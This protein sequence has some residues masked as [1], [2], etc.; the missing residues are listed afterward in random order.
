LKRFLIYLILIAVIAL[1][2]VGIY[3]EFVAP[4]LLGNTSIP[5]KLNPKKINSISITGNDGAFLLN[6]DGTWIVTQSLNGKELSVRADQ[7][8]V[9]ELLHVIFNMK[10][11]TAV[12]GYSSE[13]AEE[14]GFDNPVVDL[15]LQEEDRSTQLLF[16]P[17]KGHKGLYTWLSSRAQRLYRVDDFLL[18]R[19][20]RPFLYYQNR[21]VLPF[22]PTKVTRFQLTQRYAGGWTVVRDKEGF[23]FELPLYL[24]DK[25]ASSSEIRFYLLMLAGLN[26]DGFLPSGTKLPSEPEAILTVWGASDSPLLMKI[27]K[28]AFNVGGDFL[29]TSSFQ[30]GIFRLDNES[31]RQLLKTPFDLQSRNVVDLDIGKVA[32]ITVRDFDRTSS[33]HKVADGWISEN[34]KKRVTGIDMSLW[35]F[36]ELKFEALPLKTLPKTAS[37]LMSCEL[38]D[39]NDNNIIALKFFSDSTLPSGQSWLKSDGELYYPVANQIMNDLRG[40]LPRKSMK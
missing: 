35:R 21:L 9:D 10:P 6:R 5:L 7:G 29:A 17:R 13:L 12:Y 33:V 39:N 40:L 26:A 16:G 3:F 27:Y 38:Q 20:S 11:R 22:D 18:D 4:N 2:A 36:K 37:W 25:R 30:P 19:V 1:L 14:Y 8:K 24:I 28:T 32:R 23:A 34:T 15:L 31:V